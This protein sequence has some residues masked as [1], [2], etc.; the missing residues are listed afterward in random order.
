MGGK[1]RSQLSVF[2]MFIELIID[3]ELYS[4]HWDFRA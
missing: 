4:T 1:L 2:D 3:T